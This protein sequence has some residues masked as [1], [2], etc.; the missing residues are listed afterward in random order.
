MLDI[1]LDRL[2]NSSFRAKLTTAE[3]AAEMIKDGMAVGMSGF[4]GAGDPKAVPLALANRV[5]SSQERLGI[6]LYAG[7]SVGEE[8]ETALADAG[9]VEYRTPFQSNKSLRNGIN[10]GAVKF[11]DIH[12][13][14]LPQYFDYGFLPQKPDIAIVEAIA[15]T[16]EGDI[17]PTTSAGATHAIVRAAERVIVEINTSVP[18]GLCG[19]ADIYDYENP[20]GRRPMPLVS[21]EQ[22]IGTPYIKCG[23]DKIVAIVAAD[24]PDKTR[25]LTPQDDISRSISGH[26]LD[27]LEGEVSAGRLPENLLP[28]QSGIGST[29]NA[30]LLGLKD[31]RFT[32][33]RFFTE[34]LQD[35]MLELI[36]CGKADFASTT[37][38]ALSGEGR[39]LLFDNACELKN[40]IVLRSQDISNGS[41]AIRR[42]GVIAM[43]T[44]IEADIYGN[45]N[46][47]HI[48]GTRMMNGIGGSGD[49]AA[50]A[51]LSVFST[52]STAKSGSISAIVPMV[53]HVDHPEHNVMVLVTEQGYAD[54]RGLCPR[55]RA[56]A[57]IEKCAHPDYRPLLEDYFERAC[58]RGGHTPHILSE[59]LSWHVRCGE[60]GS[61][62]PEK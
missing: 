50:N 21:A 54:L 17:Y 10:S 46:S 40:K 27:F 36:M 33:L 14:M 57:I 43:N 47:T 8:V 44:A 37:S 42:L 11:T 38:L 22:R 26:L 13:G 30:V 1:G 41:E 24:K 55:D 31:S 39:K 32:G 56:R 20:P 2:G 15:L 18:L 59:A 35:G 49:F 28:L 53:S 7:A 51:Y 48:L 62:R 12:L 16:P 6:Y 3:R 23:A 29:A 25:P 61:M 58:L 5:R 45:V 4:A 52:P 19:M 60:T 9:V 34:V